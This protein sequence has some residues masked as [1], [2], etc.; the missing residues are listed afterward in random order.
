MHDLPSE[1]WSH[2]FSLAVD[3]DLIFHQPACQ[4]HTPLSESRDFRHRLADNWLAFGAIA[5]ALVKFTSASVRTLHI[6][7]PASEIPQI[8]GTLNALSSIVAAQIE[9]E[10]NEFL[11]Q[12]T[13]WELPAL[14]RLSTA[15]DTIRFLSAHGTHLLALDLFYVPAMPLP[16]IM[17]VGLYNLSLVVKSAHK[18][19]LTALCERTRFP[20]LW[21]VRSGLNRANGLFKNG[22]WAWWC[23][24]YLRAGVRLED[25]TEQIVNYYTWYS[26]DKRRLRIIVVILALLTTLKSAQAFSSF[27]MATWTVHFYSITRPGGSFTSLTFVQV[28]LIG[29]YVQSY[30][31]LSP[32]SYPATT[33]DIILSLATAYFLLKSKENVLP[34]TVGM[35]NAL[36][37]LTFQTAAPAALCA[38]FNPIFSQINMGSPGL[39]SATFNMALPKLY[40]MS[41]T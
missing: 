25:C 38:M 32:W 41:M 10:I 31:C 8:I 23:D 12:A 2:I 1:L 18:R 13:G 21:R 9:L 37:R 19:N 35:I 28:A 22:V 30:F 24:V 6:N 33:G 20:A 34:A 40:A 11:E 15:I 4:N 36:I 39:V 27:F 26:D 3:E 5:D 7:I 16:R 17:S 14:R 29:L